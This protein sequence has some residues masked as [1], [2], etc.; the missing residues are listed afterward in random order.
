MPEREK[1]MRVKTPSSENTCKYCGSQIE[2]IKLSYGRGKERI[3]SAMCPC[4]IEKQKQDK[5][6]KKRQAMKRILQQ[7]GFESGRFAEMTFDN[8]SH[9]D[10]NVIEAVKDYSRSVKLNHRNWLYLYGGCGVGK[11]HMVVAL[12]REIAL[13]RQ[14]KPTLISWVHHLSQVQQ[15]WHDSRVKIDGSLIPES[16]VLVLDDIDKRAGAQ[17]MLA[18]LYNIIDYRYIRQLPTIIT[19][20][21]SMAELCRFWDESKGCSDLSR[22]IISRIMGQLAKIV[23]MSA[24]DIRLAG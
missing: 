13:N 19:A 10:A 17:W 6:K 20:N 22:A 23:H 15:S 7:Q 3:V 16:R 21:R 8:F 12:T 11:T 9:T 24:D 4:V 18:H 2:V 1:Q 5:K 14:W